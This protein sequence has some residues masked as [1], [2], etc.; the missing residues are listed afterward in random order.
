MGEG[1]A[2]TTMDATVRRLARRIASVA[3]TSIQPAF[4]LGID[5][6]AEALWDVVARG[7]GRAEPGGGAAIAL[8]E[9]PTDRSEPST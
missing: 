8:L 7:T 9:G 5:V 4:P 1:V 3:G 6:R 2:V